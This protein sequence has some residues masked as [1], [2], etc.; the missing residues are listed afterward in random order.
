MLPN[1]LRVEAFVNGPFMENTY[2]LMAAGRALLVDPG[3]SSDEEYDRFLDAYRQSGAELLAVVL[4]HAHID[5]VLGLHRV[6]DSFD[7]PVYL[8]HTDL[9][10]WQHFSEQSALF[11]FRTRPFDFTPE[12]LEEGDSPGGLAPFTFQVLH[13]P[14]HAPDHTSLYFDDQGFLI[15]GDVLFASSIGRTDLYKG[16][17]N[18]LEASI[19]T[20]LYVLPEETRVLPGHGEETTIGREMR[21]NSFVRA[22]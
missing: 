18:L 3:F 5:H 2:L 1:E 7:V 12:P 17:A 22:V 10:L 9:Y 8:N 4:T 6:L 19:R 21:E 11:G 13:T 15:S 16:N 20:K 14:G